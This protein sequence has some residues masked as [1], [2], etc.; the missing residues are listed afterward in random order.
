VGDGIR[1]AG[2][3]SIIHFLFIDTSPSLC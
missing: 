3:F 2:P 1:N